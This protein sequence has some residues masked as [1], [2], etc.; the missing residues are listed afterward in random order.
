[1]PPKRT[2]TQKQIDKKMKKYRKQVEEDVK[3]RRMELKAPTTSFLLQIRAQLQ[4]SIDHGVSYKQIA[5]SI[6]ESF[7]FRMTEN[8]IRNFVD[9]F[10]I[11]NKKA[12]RYTMRSSTPQEKKRER[13]DTLPKSSKEEKIS[14]LSGMSSGSSDGDE[15]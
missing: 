12:S 14:K 10:L 6:E 9:S 2:I 1:M 11:V 3:V 13:R 4:S 15:F 7:E 8:S 5:K